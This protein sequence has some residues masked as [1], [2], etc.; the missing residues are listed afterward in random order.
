MQKGLQSL[1][2]ISLCL[3]HRGIRGNHFSHTPCQWRWG[4]MLFFAIFRFF[5]RNM[6]N[7][8]FLIYHFTKFIRLYLTVSI[9]WSLMN[10]TEWV[11]TIQTKRNNVFSSH[12]FST[13]SHIVI[14]SSISSSVTF[15]PNF[16]KHWLISAAEIKPFPSKSKESKHCW[17]SSSE[18]CLIRK[19][20]IVNW[21]LIGSWYWPSARGTSSFGLWYA[22]WFRSPTSSGL[23][24]DEDLNLIPRSGG[25]A[26]FFCLLSFGVNALLKAFMECSSPKLQNVTWIVD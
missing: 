10:T 18:N 24:A 23:T 12:W 22:N 5:A 9:L 1:F 14:I 13:K 16:L 26:F 15:S 8:R 21:P 3:Q 20:L 11:L 25:R 19:L 6:V 2:S 7:T 17:T 4:K